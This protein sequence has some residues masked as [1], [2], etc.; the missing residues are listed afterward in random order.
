MKWPDVG[1][2]NIIES[3]CAELGPRFRGDERLIV[4][5]TLSPFVPAKAGTQSHKLRPCRYFGFQFFF[6]AGGSSESISTKQIRHGL[7]ELFTQA[8]LVPCWTRMS[9]AFRCTC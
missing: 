3:L 9:P 8:W 1:P 5:R 6:Q 4:W 7:P 2:A